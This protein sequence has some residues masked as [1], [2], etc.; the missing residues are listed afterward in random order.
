M[1]IVENTK[2]INNIE[3]KLIGILGS[4]YKNYREAWSKADSNNIPN[5]PIH[6]DMEFY[7]I[8]NQKC[9]FCPRNET[10][11]T[12]LLYKINTNI[13]IEDR[14]IEKIINECKLKNLMSINFGAFAEP[15]VYRD[16]FKIIKKF[17]DIGIA[18]SR[19]ITNGL[20]LDKFYDQVFDSGLINLYI[21]I[22]AFSESTYN[23]QRGHG[24]KKV[25][26]N[27]LNFLEIKKNKKSQLPIVRVSF[28]ETDDNKH[29]LKDFIEFW[30][31]KVDHIDLQ[32]K[33][34]YTKNSKKNYLGKNWNCID[35]FRRVSIISDGSILPCCSFW[36]RSLIIG[37]IRNISIKDAWNSLEMK[38]IRGDLL[39]DKSSICNACQSQN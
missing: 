37:N 16:I 12:N 15:L 34:D 5:F 11:H 38:K 8:C 23:V 10:I 25:I 4:K 35:P 18:D 1:N 31:D 28:V 22:D 27:L 39:L 13:K 33:I 32:K 36:G 17:T 30:K 20:L 9:I 7:D 26:N 3:Q 2:T 14:L 19:L 24:F 6:L 29:E 21:S